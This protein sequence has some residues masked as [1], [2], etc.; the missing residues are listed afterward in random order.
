MAVSFGPLT[1]YKLHARMFGGG[2]DSNL[3][4]V[5]MNYVS[6]QKLINLM[7]LILKDY[8][9]QGHYVTMDVAYMGNIMAQV[10]QE[11]WGMNMVGTVQCNQ[12]GVDTTKK[13][14]KMKPGT[15]NVVM[16]QHSN[17][18]LMIAAWVDNS[19]V[20]TLSNC[21]GPEVVAAGDGVNRKRKG[22]YGKRERVL[23][24]VPYPAQMKY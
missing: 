18:P 2:N 4:M 19:V 22:N 17:K 12:L 9:G 15:Y 1:G 3:G 24:E 11:V 23:T 16:W 21:H 20:K 5:L 6:I 10:G 8:K 7:L 14:K 13:T